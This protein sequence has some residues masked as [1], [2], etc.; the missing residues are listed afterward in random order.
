VGLY[1]Q[2]AESANWAKNDELLNFP[3]RMMGRKDVRDVGRDRRSGP[4]FE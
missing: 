3:S 2:L 4:E 1:P